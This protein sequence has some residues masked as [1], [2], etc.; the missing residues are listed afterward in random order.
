MPAALDNARKPTLHAVQSGEY[1]PPARRRIALTAS[2]SP[3]PP[4]PAIVHSAVVFGVQSC[5]PL[6]SCAPSACH[7]EAQKDTLSADALNDKTSKAKVVVKKDDIQ[8]K[9][10]VKKD[11]G[12]Q[13]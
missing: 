10:L 9:V 13:A 3:H 5:Y 8:A 7:L 2:P 4:L 6:T 11:D 12:A 1:R